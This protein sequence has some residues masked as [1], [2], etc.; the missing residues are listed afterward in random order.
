MRPLSV[1]FLRCSEVN[2]ALS[3]GVAGL[4]VWEIWPLNGDDVNYECALKPDCR[5][6]QA[7]LA[8]Q[9]A[10]TPA[11][12]AAR[13]SEC[14]NLPRCSFNYTQD[15]SVTILKMFGSQLLRVIAS[16]LLGHHLHFPTPVGIPAGSN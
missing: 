5:C 4:M 9:H 14:E 1:P 15:G 10:V 16:P 2:A 7:P 6:P 8:Q 3:Y 13:C 12:V 11:M